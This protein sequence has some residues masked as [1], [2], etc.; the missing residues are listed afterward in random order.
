VSSYSRVTRYVVAGLDRDDTSEGPRAA[1]G[2][3]IVVPET[4]FTEAH[5]M[6]GTAVETIALD[7]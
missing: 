5:V 4:T 7:A 1:V 2:G 3:A 6:E